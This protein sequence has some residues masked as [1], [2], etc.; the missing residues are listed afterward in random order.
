MVISD[1]FKIYIIGFLVFCVFSSKNIIIYNEETL[2]ALSFLAFVYCIFHY[3]GNVII[4]SLNERSASIKTE[5]QNFLILKQ[6]SLTELLKQCKKVSFLKKT[7]KYLGIFTI[8]EIKTFNDLGEKALNLLIR[9]QIQQKLKTVS[10]AQINIQQKLQDSISLNIF[11]FVLV[12]FQRLKKHL[13]TL[14]KGKSLNLKIIKNALF[15]LS[16]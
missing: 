2:V 14:K 10:Y 3:F 8:S 11:I 9:H 13:K 5:L 16:K 7:V 4:E 6:Q 1:K 15:L 12:K